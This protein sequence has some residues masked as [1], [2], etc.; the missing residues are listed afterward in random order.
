MISHKYK[1][2]FI[3]IPKCAG[4]SIESKLG[5]LDGHNGRSG[6]DHR[7][8]RMLEQP[9]LIPNT[10]FSKENIIELLRR[11]KHLL[12][13]DTENQ[14]NKYTVTRQQYNSYFKFSVV[15]NPW[16]RAVSWYKNVLNDEIHLKSHGITKE[17]SFKEFILRFA[18]K[19]MLKPQ[20][21]WLKSFNGSIPLD[22]IGRFE[23][24][25]EVFQEIVERLKLDDS[26]FPHLYKGSGD[27]YRKYFDN[28][29]IDVITYIYKEDIDSFNYKFD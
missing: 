2:I 28:E 13:N 8:I 25:Q 23:N 7:S 3:H 17:I 11:E 27:D 19:G 22:Y 5:H 26:S 14:R 21:N 9:F 6:Q 20:I 29:T 1:C 4:T 12:L 18:G 24:L 10:L 15:R 16:D